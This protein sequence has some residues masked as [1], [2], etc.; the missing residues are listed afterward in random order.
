MIATREDGV[1]FLDRNGEP[2]QLIDQNAGLPDE[3]VSAT[4]ADRDGAL[5]VALHGGIAHIEVSSPMTIFDRR[6]GLK[7]SIS[8]VLRHAG[9]MYVGSSHGLYVID[10]QARTGTMSTVNVARHIDGVPGTVWDLLS[11]GADMLA[12]TSDGMY[13]VH[14][15]GTSTPISGTEHVVAYTLLRSTSDPSRAWMSTRKTVAVLRH[16]GAPGAPACRPNE[17]M[18]WTYAGPVAGSPRYVRTMLERDGALWCGTVFD[19]AIRIDCAARSRACAS[20]E[21][22]RRR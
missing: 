21:R 14:R 8:A 13:I 18:T 15:D 4:F 16:C 17:R 22:A 9:A 10:P 3:V 5:W 2:N 11:D 20:T 7:G 6:A 19:G 1:L 12:A